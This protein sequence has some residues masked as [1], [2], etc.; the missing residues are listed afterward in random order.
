MEHMPRSFKQREMYG[1]AYHFLSI[2]NILQVERQPE[3]V[4]EINTDE[5]GRII[6]RPAIEEPLSPIDILS[7]LEN[8]P[9]RTDRL[10]FSR[11]NAAIASALGGLALRDLNFIAKDQQYPFPPKALGALS[12]RTRGLHQHMG[13]V[14]DGLI[15]KSK[16]SDPKHLAVR[17]NK[18]GRLLYFP[19][20][21]PSFIVRD[22]EIRKQP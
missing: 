18:I 20:G 19:E 2:G 17:M 1:L 14:F 10:E 8:L 6:V 7:T 16:R 13:E 5:Y 11:E 4:R 22:E 9:L 15:L 12:R 3:K 21:M